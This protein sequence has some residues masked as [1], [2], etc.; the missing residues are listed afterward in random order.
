VPPRACAPPL[1]AE[2]ANAAQR[3]EDRR[4]RGP[5]GAA[6]A[7]LSLPAWNLLVHC[8]EANAGF[9]VYT[10]L[11]LAIV[12]LIFLGALTFVNAARRGNRAFKWTGRGEQQARE[13][14]DRR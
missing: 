8:V 10:L 11:G 3:L 12:V 2:N 13:A 14:Q 6:R 9:A 1:L 7:G 5:S 4:P